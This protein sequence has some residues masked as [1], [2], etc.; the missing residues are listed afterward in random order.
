M[1]YF[2]ENETVKA[3][4]ESRGAELKSI[5]RKCDNAEILWG[6]DPAYW[7]KTSPLLFPFIG[8]LQDAGYN[9]KGR[10]YQIDKHGF[11]QRMEFAVVE[12]KKDRIV[13]RLHDTEETMQKYPFSFVLD[14]EYLLQENSVVEN[15]YVTNNSAETM[16][17]SIG[18]HAA[19]ACP[20]PTRVGQRIKLYG[21]EGKEVLHSLLINENGLIKDGALAVELQE[22]K[23]AITETTFD[24]DTFIFDKGEITAIGL[25]DESGEE[26]VRVESDAPVWGIWSMP[27]SRACY[28][29]LEPW[30]GICDYADYQGSIEERAFTNHI[31]AGEVW[32]G[33]Q[34]I[35]F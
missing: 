25:C 30:Y 24:I 13:F 19:L 28:V 20:A 1:R 3:E 35:K 29:C 10:R 18:G 9:Y 6:A 2:L 23:F 15:W 17:F 31:Q 7:G 34:V 27:D 5:V 8:K 26:Y 16:Y 14:V 22:G 21:V 33:G 32:R 4:V 11:A 12:E